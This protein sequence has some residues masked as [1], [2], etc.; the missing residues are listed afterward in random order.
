MK[1]TETKDDHP[2]FGNVHLHPHSELGKLPV[3]E[4]SIAYQKYPELSA[5]NG[6]WYSI[7]TFKYIMGNVNLFCNHI[8]IWIYT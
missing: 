3:I 4:V 5:V 1:N 2:V 7:Q 8:Y 6:I